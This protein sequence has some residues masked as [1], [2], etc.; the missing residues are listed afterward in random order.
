M[1][2]QEQYLSIGKVAKLLGVAIVTLRRWEKSGK[3]VAK[4]RTFGNHRLHFIDFLMPFNY[5]K[6]Y[7]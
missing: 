2:N 1:N 4:F 5:N 3:L 7:G 6:A